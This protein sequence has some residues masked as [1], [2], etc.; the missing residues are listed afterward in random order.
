MTNKPTFHR[1]DIDNLDEAKLTPD[2]MRS[3]LSLILGGSKN[4][5]THPEVDIEALITTIKTKLAQEPLIL[6]P[7]TLKYTQCI[8]VKKIVRRYGKSSCTAM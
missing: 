2:D 7:L 3:V 1:K 6:N 8:D 5:Y 4:D